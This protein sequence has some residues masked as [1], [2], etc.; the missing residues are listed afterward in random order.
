[1]PTAQYTVDQIGPAGLLRRLGGMVYDFMILIAIWMITLFVLVALN[2]G[3][4]V[5]G[6]GL[7]VLLFLETFFFFAWFWREDGQTVGMM[8][9]RMRVVSNTGEPL[10]LV[11][12]TTRFAGACL[13]AMC[14]G[15]GYLWM[16]VDP[17]GRSWSD[18]MSDSRVIVEP[19]QKKSGKTTDAQ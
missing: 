3:N 17:D 11:Q 19:K 18:I 7:Q 13:A 16:L 4:A 2:G 1:M 14:L 5:T 10:T 9:W 12:I 8:A 6:F 15:L